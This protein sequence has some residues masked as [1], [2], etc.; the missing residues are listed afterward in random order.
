MTID[1]AS[2][3]TILTTIALVLGVLVSIK[4]LLK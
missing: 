3:D 1:V 4:A 2:L